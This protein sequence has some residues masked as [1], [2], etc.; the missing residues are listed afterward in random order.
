[1]IVIN[2]E[3]KKDSENYRKSVMQLGFEFLEISSFF[4][5]MRKP[6]SSSFY[7]LENRLKLYGGLEEIN[8][9]VSMIYLLM[10]V[11]GRA[12]ILRHPLGKSYAT[13]VSYGFCP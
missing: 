2:K 1:M 10:W 9:L 12:S 3:I 13:S 11:F 7:R 4:G 8:L 5:S 6:S